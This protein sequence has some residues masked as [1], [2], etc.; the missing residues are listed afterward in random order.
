M[1]IPEFQCFGVDV[2]L[3]FIKKPLNSP[4][5]SFLRYGGFLESV[6]AGKLH[7][8]VL[9]VTWTYGDPYRN[10]LKL[11]LGELESRTESV[12]VIYLHSVAVCLEL[13]PELLHL[14]K[15][16]CALGITLIY[17]YHHHLDRRKCRRE[18]KAVVIS[19]CHDKRPH[20]AC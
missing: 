19:V 4:A 16:G 7:L 12:P 10:S 8:P 15:D 17:R 20:K 9:Q 6:P 14:V 11:P 18:D 13:L 2:I 1:F 3:N 5:Q